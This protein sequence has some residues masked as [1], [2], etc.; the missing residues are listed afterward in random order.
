MKMIVWFTMIIA[1]NIWMSCFA[2]LKSEIHFSCCWESNVFADPKFRLDK[3]PRILGFMLIHSQHYMFFTLLWQ[4]L[5]FFYLFIFSICWH[6][7]PFFHDLSRNL[8]FLAIFQQHFIIFWIKFTIF[9]TIVSRNLPLSCLY[10]IL[11]T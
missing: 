8:Y 4:N 6:N 2:S 5:P 10:A 1:V 9:S 11:N 3:V 7:L